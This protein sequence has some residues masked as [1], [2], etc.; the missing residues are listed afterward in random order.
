MLLARLFSTKKG[1]L[2]FTQNT[3]VALQMPGP[4][5]LDR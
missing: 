4:Q 1:G 5:N 2:V 3:E